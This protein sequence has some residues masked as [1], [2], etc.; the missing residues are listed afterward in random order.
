MDQLIDNH[1]RV[2]SDPG[3]DLGLWHLPAFFLSGS[4]QSAWSFSPFFIGALAI[5]VI[6]TAM[7]NASRGSLLIAALYHFQING[8]AW[9]DAQPWDTLVFD[10][11]TLVIVLLKAFFR[12]PGT[13]S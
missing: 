9:P 4:P 10:V 6:L 7:F 13:K 2:E 5:T 8:P 11:A 12:L 3:W 1:N